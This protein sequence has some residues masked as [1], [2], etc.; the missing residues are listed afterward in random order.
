MMMMV[1]DGARIDNQFH[2]RPEYVQ[3]PPNWMRGAFY[4]HGIKAE[5]FGMTEPPPLLWKRK[6]HERI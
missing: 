6:A 4:P 3:R 5:D 1:G 2:N